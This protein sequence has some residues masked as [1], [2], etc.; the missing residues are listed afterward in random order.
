MARRNYGDL[1]YGAG[2]YGNEDAVP[3][4]TEATWQ[5]VTPGSFEI[6]VIRGTTSDTPSVPIS[7]AEITFLDFE[8]DLF[9]FSP[10]LQ[11][12]RPS[13]GTYTRVSVVSP[14]GE[15]H[16]LF[17]GRVD[18]IADDHDTRVRD[19]GVQCFGIEADLSTTILGWSSP[20][21][22]YTSTRLEE[23]LS[24]A[25][26]DWGGGFAPIH[27]GSSWPELPTPRQREVA[28]SAEAATTALQALDQAAQG[29][30]WVFDAD[31]DGRPRVNRYPVEV[32]GS[33]PLVGVS[34][35]K[36]EPDSLPSPRIRFAH[37]AAETLNVAEIVAPA[38]PSQSSEA[39]WVAVDGQS[40][41]EIGRRSQALGF[42]IT[43]STGTSGAMQPLVDRLVERYADVFVRVPEFEVDSKLDPRWLDILYALDRGAPVIVDRQGLEPDYP[44]QVAGIVVGLRHRLTRN[45]WETVVHCTTVS[46]DG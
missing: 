41:A 16:T 26:F 7:E 6:S 14:E 13:V 22:E 17:L 23:I 18:S 12:Q 1:T 31:L 30:G 10:S 27:N 28:N 15:P 45:R 33:L 5:D 37:D 3:P 21:L 36:N 40:I 11:F 8:G 9:P 46:V 43:N 24:E 42:P 19:V 32:D 34:D 39:V 38:T 20:Y 25:G 29:A 44:L 4:D 35:K 2:V